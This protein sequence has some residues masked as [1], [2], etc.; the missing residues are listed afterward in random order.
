M[1]K[2]ISGFLRRPVKSGRKRF[3]LLALLAVV[4]VLLVGAAW[5]VWGDLPSTDPAAQH[6]N[7]PSISILDRKGRLLYEALA[8][9]GGRN[10]VVPLARVPQRL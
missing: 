1:R 7:L 2:K 6:P 9:G 3:W 5:W 4:V 10:T 8:E